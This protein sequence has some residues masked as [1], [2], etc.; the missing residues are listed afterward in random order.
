MMAEMLSLIGD[1][2]LIDIEDHNEGAK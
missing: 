1:S 2:K